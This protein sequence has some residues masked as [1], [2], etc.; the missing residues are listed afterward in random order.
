M[1]TTYEGKS[2]CSGCKSRNLRSKPSSGT[3]GLVR[4]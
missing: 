1:M 3:F 2:S 4:L